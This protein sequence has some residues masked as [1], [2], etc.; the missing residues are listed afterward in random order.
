MPTPHQ[1]ASSLVAHGLL[2]DLLAFPEL[3]TIATRT[4]TFGWAVATAA[5]QTFHAL[6][7]RAGQ[8]LANGGSCNGQQATDNCGSAGHHFAPSVH[9]KRQGAY[10]IHVAANAED[11]A[12][13]RNLLWDSGRVASAESLNIAY[14]GQALQWGQSACWSVRLWPESAADE[15]GPWAAPQTFTLHASEPEEKVS[16]YP[17]QVVRLNPECVTTEA[18]G[19]L[20]VDFGKEAFCWLEV[21]IEHP[22]DGQQLKLRIGE[23]L[24]DNAQALADGC[25]HTT[26]NAQ[27]PDD[28][29][30]DATNGVTRTSPST[31]SGRLDRTPS[32]PSLRYEEETILMQEGVHSYTVAMKPGTINHRPA[33]IKLPAH[34]PGVMPFRYIEAEAEEPAQTSSLGL[35]FTQARLQYPFDLS[36]SHFRCDSTE[37][38]DI[39]DICT[40]TMLATSFCGYYVDGDRERIPYEADAFINQIGHYAVDREFSLARRSHEYLL[41]HPTW[42]TE[43]K[44]FSILIA[45]ADYM[46]TADTRSLERSYQTLVS[47]KLLLQY[48]RGDGLLVTGDLRE[49]NGGRTDCGD[50]VDWPPA[51]RDNYDLCLVNTVVNA[52]HY[53]TLVLMA[54]IAAVLGH[55]EDA[56]RYDALAH[57]QYDTFNAKLWDE[58]QGV[59]VDGE[60]SSHASI[61][62][63]LFALAFALVPQERRASVLGYLRTRGMACSVYAAQFLLDALYEAGDA[64]YAM[65]LML[66]EDLRSW[67]NMLKK[68][69]TI[70]WEAWDQSC[71]PNQD[72][73]HAWGAAPGNVI[74]RYVLGVTPLEA[75]YAKVRI[76]PQLGPLNEV[77]GLVPTIR[78]GIRVRAR[79]D[80]TSGQTRVEVCAPANI[81]IQLG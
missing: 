67:R 43:W 21:H 75:G 44:Q 14:A 56:T 36:A 57:S 29:C 47:E 37:L 30:A 49:R 71:K 45:W 33:A 50:L 81:E 66:S 25:A 51:E 60:G 10:Q 7:P 28:Q 11:L 61:H 19:T 48:A 38:N 70:T 4:P 80:A 15:P 74:S 62:A 2:C 53:R 73:N 77:E 63:N 55:S 18:D 32:T 41:K 39:W 64:D 17:L 13:A 54:K 40:Y 27:A 69:A 5:P 46:A 1:T 31:G 26:G 8:P 6:L 24:A 20:F 42:P 58:A 22:R 34:L 3:T 76:A 52:F 65:E 68:G 23:K 35:R 59:Y 9:T 79:R 16:T 78:G 72:W 12:A